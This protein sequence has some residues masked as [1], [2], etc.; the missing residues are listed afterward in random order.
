MNNTLADN[1]KDP[2]AVMPMH[3]LIKYKDTYGKTS[4]SSWQ[5]SKNET[6]HNRTDSESFKYRSRFTLIML[7]MRS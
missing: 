6:N 1:A 4:S 5:Q 7:T 2:D 3:N